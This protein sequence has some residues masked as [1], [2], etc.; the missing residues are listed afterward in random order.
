MHGTYVINIDENESIGIHQ[1]AFYVN[2]ENL[3]YFDSFRVENISI[4]ITKFIGSKNIRTNIYRIQAYN[5][6]MFVY[7]CIGFIDLLF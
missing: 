5:L 6:T 1:I 2:A 7:F 3:T 4:K